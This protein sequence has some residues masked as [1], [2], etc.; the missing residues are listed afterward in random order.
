M[1][2]KFIP[3][4]HISPH[5]LEIQAIEKNINFVWNHRLIKKVSINK[6]NY[7][8]LVRVEQA[9]NLWA[10]PLGFILVFIYCITSCVQMLYITT[11]MV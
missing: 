4:F 9:I 8:Y 7:F 5:F 3:L 1:C 10:F 6:S 2:K 11:D